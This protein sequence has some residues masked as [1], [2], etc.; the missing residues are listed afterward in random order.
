[1][2]FHTPINEH[3]IE[4]VFRL[5][6]PVGLDVVGEQR[7]LFLINLIRR[8]IHVFHAGRVYFENAEADVF[9]PFRIALDFKDFFTGAADAL[10]A[11]FSNGGVPRFESFVFF[12]A[13][14]W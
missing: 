14:F 12:T 7:K 9:I 5:V 11:Y 2:Q 10:F 3:L 4:Q 8:V 1:M 13:G 6:A